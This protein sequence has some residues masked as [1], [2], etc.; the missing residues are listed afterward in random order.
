MIDAMGNRDGRDFGLLWAGKFVSVLGDR[1]YAIAMAWWILNISGSPGIMGLYMVVVILPGI[2]FGAVSG[3]VIDRVNQKTILIWADVFQGV[4]IGIL[5]LLFIFDRVRIW[6]VFSVSIAVSVAFSFFNPDVLTIIPKLVDSENLHKA[7]SKMQMING[8]AKITGPILGVLTVSILGYQGA[9]AI[10]AVSYI[11]S[12]ISE[13]FIPYRH[14]KR[15]IAE[16]RIG[17]SWTYSFWNEFL[18]GWTVIAHNR[19]LL[20]MMVLI[21]MGHFFIGAVMVLMPVVAE[22]HAETGIRFLGWRE[23]VFGAGYLI[24]AFVVSRKKFIS[25]PLVGVR[26]YF[27]GIALSFGFFGML[28][29]RFDPAVLFLACGLIFIPV[30]L[31]YRV[32]RKDSN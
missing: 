2:L 3:V 15:D 24:G 17:Q 8:F 18:E 6:H 30:V 7:N 11:L 28:A 27:T 4:L 1:I 29:G 14:V 26:L 9:I 22:V 32:L 23:I 31:P 13:A 5:V 20:T 12:A 16:V 21:T 10:N 25:N 19:T